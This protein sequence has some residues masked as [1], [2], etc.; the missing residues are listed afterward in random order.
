MW[1][2][3]KAATKSE[4]DQS[5]KKPAVDDAG[6]DRPERTVLVKPGDS[7]WSISEQRLGSEASSQQVYDHT[8]QMSALNRKI[9]GD[10]PYLIFVGQRFSPPPLGEG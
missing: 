1:E 7:L 3:P 4:G 5:T 10:D 6:R 2:R 9:I 8:L